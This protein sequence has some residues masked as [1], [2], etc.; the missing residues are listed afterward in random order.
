MTASF[1]PLLFNAGESQLTNS[2]ENKGRAGGL[3]LL[4]EGFIPL[5]EQ[6]VV[7]LLANVIH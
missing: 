2:L 3:L 6:D 4:F 5:R 7:D 1:A